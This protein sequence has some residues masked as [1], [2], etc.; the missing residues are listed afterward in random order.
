MDKENKK[1]KG[2]S[3]TGDELEGS[4][5]RVGPQDMDHSGQLQG[6]EITSGKQ[7]SKKYHVPTKTIFDETLGDIMSHT[8]DFVTY[9]GDN[10]MKKVYEAETILQGKDQGEIK[11]YQKYLTGFSLFCL[12]DS[13]AIYLG[14]IMIFVSLIIYFMSIVTT[15]DTNVG[16]T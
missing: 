11:G 2:P 15:N 7:V 8:L 4:T 1:L 9:S 12:H 14:I 10:Y 6:Y 3:D 16:S 5:E 13:N